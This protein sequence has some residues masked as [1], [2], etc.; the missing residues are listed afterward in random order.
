M[1]HA[2]VPIPVIE[3]LPL[4][5]AS[6]L[7]VGDRFLVGTDN[8]VLLV[9]TVREVPHSPTAPTPEA[10][11]AQDPLASSVTTSA[12]GSVGNN[13]A[14]TEPDYARLVNL[15]VTFELVDCLKGFSKR[16]I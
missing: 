16:A 8:G 15:Q 10:S 6:V 3:Q 9:Y 11:S 12:S 4:T 7:A 13:S 14:E 5:I 2:F 1:H